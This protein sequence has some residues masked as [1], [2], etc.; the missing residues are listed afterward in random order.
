MEQVGILIAIV[1]I[2]TFL[3]LKF[4]NRDP[5][6]TLK[7]MKVEHARIAEEVNRLRHEARVGTQEQAVRKLRERIPEA[8][9][10]LEEAETALARPEEMD[11]MAGRIV[12]TA[13]EGGLI[14]KEFKEIRDA[15]ALKEIL[16]S[17]EDKALYPQRYFMIVLKGRFLDLQRFVSEID[18]LPKLVVV[19][20]VA[21][22]KLEEEAFIRAALWISI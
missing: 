15:V 11:R 8:N 17:S 16:G 13:A 5:G 20:K 4:V 10:R 14:I 12:K 6:R 22:E 2:G 7:R 18:G 3:Y 9:R 1:V 21:I 19:R